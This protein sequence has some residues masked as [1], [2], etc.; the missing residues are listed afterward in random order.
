MVSRHRLLFIAGNLEIATETIDIEHFNVT[1]D[2]SVNLLNI[3]VMII[4]LIALS[5][6]I[7]QYLKVQKATIKYYTYRHVRVKVY[8]N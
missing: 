1:V 3:D 2:S 4:I 5:Y 8:N 6:C 7:G